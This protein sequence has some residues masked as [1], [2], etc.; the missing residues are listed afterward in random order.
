MSTKIGSLA[1]SLSLDAENWNGSM[2]QVDRSLRTMGSELRA[3]KA[4]GTDYGKSIDGLK[5]KKDILTRSVEASSIKLTEER[6]KYDELVESGKASEAQ[7]ERQAKKVNDAQVQYN[8]LT[9]ELGEVDK[10]L[11]TQSSSWTQLGDKLTATGTKMKSFGDGMKSV[12]KDL[13]LKVTAP[14]VAMGAA[15]FKMAVDYESAFAGVRKTVDMTE[16]EF[17]KLS[18]GIREMTKDIPAA[19]TEIAGV[20]EAAGQL[21]VQNDAILG[22]TRVMVD[23]G[24]ATDMNSESAAMSLARLATITQMNQQDFDRLGSTVVGLGNNLA[25]TESEIVEMGLRLAGAG[26]VIGMTEAQ[27]LGFSG[28]LAA[29]GINAE[30]GGSAF[31][32]LFINAANLAATGGEGLT[33][34]AKVA[35]MSAKEFQTAFEEDASGAIISFIEGLGKINEAGGNVFGVLDDLGLSEI[36][37]RDALLRASGAGDTLRESIDLGTKSWEENNALTNEAEERYKT[38]ASQMQIMWNK[39]TDIGISIGGIL[40]PKVTALMDK[41][42]PLIDS[43][44]NMSSE[45]QN[46]ILALA[47][48]AAAI[49]PVL[50]VGGSLLSGLGGLVTVA[51]A[52]STALG[53]GGVGLGGTLAALAGPIG[54]TVLGIGAIGT[55]GYQ[56]YKVLN[57]TS[58]PEIDIFG[59]KVSENTKEAVGA[60]TELTNEATVQLNQLKW[61]GMIVSEEMAGEMIATYG[62]MGDEIL[63]TMQED[64]AKQLATARE[65]FTNSKTLTE[66]E[67]KNYLKII[68]NGQAEREES[69]RNAQ[70]QYNSIV[71]N[72]SEER[73]SLTSLEKDTLDE[74]QREMMETGIRYLSESEEESLIILERLKTESGKINAEQAIETAARAKE[75]KEAVVEEAEKKYEEA[76]ALAILLKEDGSAEAIEMANAIIEEAERTRDNTIES[77]EGQYESIIRIAKEKGDEYV[78]ETELRVGRVMETWEK[79]SF[80]IIVD[81]AAMTIDVKRNLVDM[82]VTGSNQFTTLKNNG[83]ESVK[84]LAKGIVFVKVDVPRIIREAVRDAVLEAVKSATEFYKA[85]Q[86]AAQGLINGLKSKVVDVGVESGKLGLKMIQSVNK[87]IGRQSPAKEFI[88]ITEDAGEGLIVG[89]NNIGGKVVSA[90]VGVG[91]AMTNEL[92]KVLKEGTQQTNAE[93]ASINKK[94][95][96]EIAQ[97]EKRSQEDINLIYAKAKKAKRKVTT[98]EAIRIR[99]IEEDTAKKVKKVNEKLAKDIADIEKKNFNNSKSWIDER[100]YYNELSLDAELIAWKRVQKRYKKGTEERKEA[101]RQVYRVKQ[102]IIRAEF[103][104]S[105]NWIDKRKKYGDLSL[106]DELAAWERVQLRYKEGTKER[107]E[108]D[109]NVYNTK[110]AIHDKVMSL[111]DEMLASSQ[112]INDDLIKGIDDLNKAY[113]DA[114]NQRSSA[115]KSFKSVFDEFNWESDTTGDQLLNNLQDQ[116]DGFKIW[117]NELGKLTTK[118]VADGLLEELRQL[119]PSALP[120]LIALNQLTKEQL[121]DYVSLYD[122]KMRLAREQTEMELFGMK[123]DTEKQ[124]IA[125]KKVAND[126]LGKLQV[127]WSKRIES[128]TKS[129]SDEFKSLKTIGQQAGQNLLDGLSSMENSLIAKARQIAS[130]VNQSLQG[131]LGGSVDVPLIGGGS[132]ASGFASN[133][134]VGDTSYG[135]SNININGPIYMRN[136]GDVKMLARELDTLQTNRQRGLGIR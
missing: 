110:K 134:G 38:T 34:F 14:I 42:D 20:A 74:L 116:V 97:L 47:G 113:D 2:A 105:K 58:I 63:S 79:A 94:A 18:G 104:F 69:V 73:R 81:V 60:F 67:Q 88:K 80:S 93:I 37:L 111:N 36:R 41:V 5:S 89:W 26:N 90:S 44:A 65:Y 51:G 52:A 102:E 72:A 130:A 35:G 64:H 120:E 9:T 53:V 135:D 129:T 39:I 95:R 83:I 49:G 126:E 12:G 92:S 48:I 96:K 109:L 15:A 75:A 3:T 70:I 28:A 45:S 122:E 119:G 56:L 132:Y 100:K 86:D 11:K 8:R 1:V 121:D 24:V 7:L 78:T 21:G 29:V 108:A 118:G 61:S 17:A 77:A 54:W 10:A 57:E 82:A 133:S 32:K 115:L 84:G 87:A 103:D 101:D 124:I 55:A 123:M 131:A 43:F 76:I 27:I 106:A 107:E 62:Q 112:K 71:Q 46:T 30:A 13:S 127:D 22:F 99:R 4:M 136:D 68:E 114:F 31:S 25:A 128:I 85:G 23:M 98:A 66:E 19:A 50:V 33:E 6:R 40:I 125:L 91:T 16:S 117:Q 59:D